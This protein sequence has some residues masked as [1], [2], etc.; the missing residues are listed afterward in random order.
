MSELNTLLTKDRHRPPFKSIPTPAGRDSNW[1]SQSAARASIFTSP[2]ALGSYTVTSHTPSATI[3]EKLYNSRAAFKIRVAAV[4]MHLDKEWRDR[5]FAQVDSLLDADEWDEG[6]GPVVEASFMTFLRMILLLQAKRRPGL[7]AT[8]EGNVIAAWS[9][10]KDRLTIECLPIDQI[11]W[12]L[13]RY[14]DDERES[15]AGQTDVLRLPE[16]LR[17]YDPKRWFFDEE[18]AK[19]SA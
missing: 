16:V 3:E 11:R 4:A 19:A 17:P 13:V 2:A 7:G 12:V 14:L 9:V 5:L 8:S 1:I 18:G 10:G 15:A 6:D